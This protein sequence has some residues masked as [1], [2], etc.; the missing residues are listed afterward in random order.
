[1]SETQL[2]KYSTLISFLMVLPDYALKHALSVMLTTFNV[3]R[4]L[5]HFPSN[6][7]GAGKLALPGYWNGASD[8]LGLNTFFIYM[9]VVT[10]VLLVRIHAPTYYSFILKMSNDIRTTQIF[11]VNIMEHIYRRDRLDWLIRL[12][13]LPCFRKKTE[14]NKTVEA[15]ADVTKESDHTDS[16]VKSN[17]VEN[18][19]IVVSKLTKRFGKFEA[20]RDVSFTVK[21]G[22]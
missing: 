9:P 17:Q 13:R 15:T 7:S 6:V 3:L 14:E 2:T 10:V 11:L 16:V 8:L 20:V 1:M 22:N 19:A 12:C 5:E 18:Y 4:V 21:R